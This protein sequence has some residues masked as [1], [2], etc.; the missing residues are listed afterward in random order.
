LIHL[1]D[2]VYL[3]LDTLI[4]A[5]KDRIVVSKENGYQMHEVL[6]KVSAGILFKYGTSVEEVFEDQFQQII[7]DVI[8]ISRARGR[9]FYIFADKKNL[10]KIQIMWF[11][12]ILKNPD[13]IVCFNI[14]QSNA[15]RFNIYQKAF[16]ATNTKLNYST[17]K[18]K[19][20]MVF[21][22]VTTP[23]AT[24]KKMFVSK[25][26]DLLGVEYLLASY[27]HSGL[28]KEHF[29]ASVQRLV[30][31]NLDGIILE[32]KGLF[33]AFYTNIAFAERIGL[34][35]RYGLDDLDIFSD[36]SK[37][38]E[39]FLSGRLFKS[40]EITKASASGNFRF[41]QMTEEDHE[42]FRM[43]T[44][45]LGSYYTHNDSIVKYNDGLSPILRDG[46]KWQFLPIAAGNFTDD[47][48]EKLINLEAS[49][50]YAQGTFFNLNLETVN[51]HLVQHILRLHKKN[52]TKELAKYILAT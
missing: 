26:I 2:K 51:G 37:I 48:L 31:K 28:F 9:P 27:L 17:T 21:D 7:I 6:E 14:H 5:H 34:E 39:F 29:K 23:K 41:D 32:Y 33:L 44:D 24:I 11:K 35:K 52:D 15:M 46:Y 50:D 36:E 13:P 38:S 22:S 18:E 30:R 45:A 8:D 25:H 47:L 10:I 43:F 1:I 4:D 20:L 42:T 16:Y 3:C 12:L 40:R 19:F 49:I